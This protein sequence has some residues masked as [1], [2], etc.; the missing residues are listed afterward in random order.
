MAD[1]NNKDFHDLL[2]RAY[3]VALV[4]VMGTLVVALYVA[5]RFDYPILP[6]VAGA[7]VLG[8]AVHAILGK[9]SIRDRLVL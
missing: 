5:K 8:E 9:G 2:G 7:F 6:T 1:D 4:D 3:G